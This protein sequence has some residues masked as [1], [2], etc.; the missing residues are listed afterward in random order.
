VAAGAGIKREK[1]LKNRGDTHSGLKENVSRPEREH[2][3]ETQR[4]RYSRKEF[5]PLSIE[6]EK[7]TA[8]Q[9]RRYIGEQTC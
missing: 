1:M 7:A 8:S 6:K 4:A 9:K 3:R 2:V 5:T